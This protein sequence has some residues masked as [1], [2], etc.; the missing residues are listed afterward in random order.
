MGTIDA[1]D[2]CERL[3]RRQKGL[4]YIATSAI[5][6]EFLDYFLIGF[7]VT[8]VSTS[9]Q[10]TFGQSSVILLSSGLGAVVGAVF[11]GRLADRI[12]RRPV[13]LT[14]ITVFTAATAAMAFTPEDASLG[15]VYLA[16]LRVVVGFGAGG[17]TWWICRWS[18]S[19]CP[20]AS[21][22]V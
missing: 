17:S 1:L 20:P 3:T 12:G 19:S 10:L 18:R 11:F 21:G 6:L 9:W 14:T 7:I 15:W 13:F 16:V 8:F 22:G 2:T 5:C 4:A